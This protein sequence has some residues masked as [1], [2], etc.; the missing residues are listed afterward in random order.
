MTINVVC[1][2]CEYSFN[3]DSRLD[4]KRIRCPSCEAPVVV[5][6]RSVRRARL[7]HSTSRRS[8][9]LRQNKAFGARAYFIVGFGVGAAIVAI[10]SVSLLQQPVNP[11]G[12]NNEVDSPDSGPVDNNARPA[13]PNSG[14]PNVPTDSTP[15]SVQTPANAV[16]RLTPDTE[17]LISRFP[18]WNDRGMT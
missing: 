16:S 9:H 4:G 15:P 2:S 3:V 8:L 1:D 11:T 5:G 13:P 6:G 17:P 18:W 14:G 10:S 12:N 7:R